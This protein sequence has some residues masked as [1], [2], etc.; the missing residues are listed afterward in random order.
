LAVTS[1]HGN[2]NWTREEVI[3]AL[4]LFFDC[5]GSVPSENDDRVKDL[6]KL[7]RSFPHHSHASRKESFRNA[8][9]VVFKL[10]NLRQVATGKGLGN[11]SKVDREVWE[12]FGNNPLQT[13]EIAKLIRDSAEAIGEVHEEPSEYETFREG[14]IV[15]ETHRRRERDPKLRR[16]LLAQRRK[17]GPLKCDMCGMTASVNVA[18]LEDA[19]FEAHHVL[20]LASSLERKTK[21]ADMA[22]LC[23][24]CHRM[25]HRAISIEKRWLTVSEARLFIFRE[26]EN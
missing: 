21:L 3:L 4:D 2:P 5:A 17:R 16:R 11:T 6:S 25:I 8:A 26:D 13:K 20:P 22:L 10:Q 7:L 14:R 1:G 12:E 24:N 19:M 18:G 15:T 23:A 9:G